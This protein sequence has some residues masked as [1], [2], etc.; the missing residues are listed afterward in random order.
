MLLPSVRK[1]FPAAQKFF[2]F[3]FAKQRQLQDKV[4]RAFSDAEQLTALS[5]HI[6]FSRKVG[7]I[8]SYIFQEEN[9]IS[10]FQLGKE[11][12]GLIF[13]Y[14][15]CGFNIKMNTSSPGGPR[16]QGKALFHC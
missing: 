4:L 8:T 5:L 13:T 7:N 16:R 14:K 15:V 9:K 12:V 1:S 11:V 2:Q 3:L 6:I 10:I